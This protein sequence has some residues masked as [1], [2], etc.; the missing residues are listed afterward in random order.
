MKAFSFG[1]KKPTG[2]RRPNCVRSF[3]RAI[4]R[5]APGPN[6]CLNV[7]AGAPAAAPEMAARRDG[8]ARALGIGSQHCTAHSK[9]AGACRCV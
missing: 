1:G 9:E 4:L 2:E 6:V 8:G 5:T 3:R 7:A